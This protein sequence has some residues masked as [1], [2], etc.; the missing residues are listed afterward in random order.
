M[1]RP[2]WILAFS[3]LVLGSGC[4]ASAPQTQA[5]DSSGGGG[6]VQEGSLESDTNASSGGP[7]GTFALPSGSAAGVSLVDFGSANQLFVGTKNGRL[8]SLRVLSRT[9]VAHSPAAKIAAPIAAVAP[10]GSLAV[11]NTSPP[12][13]VNMTGDLI[14]NANASETMT[15]AEFSKGDF[16]LYMS[17]PDGTVRIWGQAH[18]FVAPDPEEKMESYLNRQGT[19]FNIRL[20]PLRGPIHATSNGYLILTDE[21]GVVRLWTVRKPTN[22]KRIMKLDSPVKSVATS[23]ADIVTT[24]E[25]GSLKVGHLDPPEYFPWSREEK[26]DYAATS[27]FFPGKF[28]E[29]KNGAL[30]GRKIETGEVLWTTALPA[31]EPCGLDVSPD[32]TL[33]AA[34]IDGFV[35]VFYAADGK[36]D[37]TVYFEGANL[38]WQDASGKDIPIQ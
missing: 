15:A 29:L 22:S 11:L 14:L 33:V 25:A 20:A 32:G 2:L 17:A 23:D 37:S 16:T 13:V 21:E 35:G 26:A 9:A 10:D 6:G 24:S 3:S 5:G 34:C 31:G 19:D 30:R 18:N 28:V 1:N 7:S 38:K 4:G 8:A 12:K 27:D 36:W